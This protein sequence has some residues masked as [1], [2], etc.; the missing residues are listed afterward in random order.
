VTSDARMARI[1]Q[2]GIKLRFDLRR[3]LQIWG[4][5]AIPA[6]LLALGVLIF[7]AFW[8]APVVRESTELRVAA[9]RPLSTKSAFTG[10]LPSRTP[11]QWLASF[12]EG[13]PPSTMI[14]HMTGQ[15]SEFADKTSVRVSEADFHEATDPS[16]LTRYD[17]V[18]RAHGTYPQLRRF[19]ALCLTDLPS[20][21][22]DGLT[23]S[24]P[25]MIHRWTRSIGCPYSRGKNNQ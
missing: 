18:L 8:L 21:A 24:H 22:L 12:E 7:G 9:A 25:S 17:V 23:L 14:L 20:L 3:G 5:A 13:F 2:A 16:G 19:T 15:L 10:A 11:K 6:V 4:V 1:G